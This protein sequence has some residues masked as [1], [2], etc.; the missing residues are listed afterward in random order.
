M[1][2]VKVNQKSNNNKLHFEEN[3]EFK[4]DNHINHLETFFV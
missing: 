4:N 2:S 1:S 3:N